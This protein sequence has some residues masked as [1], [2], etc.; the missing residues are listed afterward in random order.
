MAFP[1]FT[2]ASIRN[3]VRRLINEPTATLITDNDIDDWIDFGVAEIAQRSLTYEEI[4][5]DSTFAL[6]DGS[7]RYAVTGRVGADCIRVHT[8][9]YTAATAGSSC[10]TGAYAL[11]K[12]TP[13]HFRKLTATTDGAPIYWTEYGGYIYLNPTPDTAQDGKGIHVL[14]YK[15]IDDVSATTITELPEYMQEYVVFYCVA[16]SF[17]KMGKHEQAQQY[18]SIF[19]N[20]IMFHREDNFNKP[21][22]SKDLMRLPD[23]TQY[24]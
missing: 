12:V 22:D 16:K 2:D 20:F 18:M 1:T 4:L 23:R 9:I 3:M 21:V 13:R 14:Y 6:A 10:A 24:V 15:N 5:Y 7:E 17:E 8:L 19:D 11:I